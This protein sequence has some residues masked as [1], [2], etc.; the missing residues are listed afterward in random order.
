MFSFLKSLFFEKNETVKKSYQTP[1][2]TKSLK[3]NIALFKAIFDNDDTIIY[4][5]CETLNGSSCC[6]IFVD[7]MI[8]NEVINKNVI[9]RIMN[10]PIPQDISTNN[11][12]DFFTRKVIVVDDI[13][14]KT[15]L[16]EITSSILYGD[17]LLL[18]DGVKEGLLLNS[19][20]WQTRAISEPETENVV[21]GPREGF[22]ESMSLNISLLR[23]K[24]RTPQ[25]KF[26]FKEMGLRT[27][28]KICICYIEDLASDKILK[29]AI[30]RLNAIDID[31]ILESGY[32]EEF[33]Q[34]SPLSLFKTIGNTERPD[35]LAG[36]LLEGRI[37]ILCDGTPF[38]L[39]FPYV[40]LENFQA[41]ED[42]YNNF[43]VASLNRILRYIGFFL[44]TSIPAIYLALITYH[45]EMI[46]TPL[47]L[48]ISAARAGIPFPTVVETLI[49]GLS[50]EI[51][52]EGGVRLPKPI[53]QAL[54]IVGAI[55]IGEA[56]ATAK[57]ISSPMVIV[58]ALTGISGFATPKML[59]AAVLIRLTF[60]L[61]A[62]FFGMYGYMFG[63]IGL[64]IHLMSL[65][66]FGVPYMINF[67]SLKPQDL[68]DTV[69][70]APWWYMKLRPKLINK[71]NFKRQAK[72]QRLQKGGK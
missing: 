6:L 39:T 69:I 10:Y 48:S 67:D 26:Q 18:I 33:I 58:T 4:R 72:L 1:Q 66:S 3:K 61:L 2:I 54:N 37:G 5:E 64:F 14:N 44:T 55:V 19:K 32:I 41:N 12:I 71:K 53:G 47:L 52:R 8:N 57:L 50:F 17:T 27:K 31:G 15:D 11:L 45:Q 59:G 34:D 20:G 35:I 38:A 13:K 22:T 70:R 40:F 62:S 63:V 16:D 30:K 29:E 65:R 28:T 9:E 56:A 42:Y 43:I 36:K 49:I 24:I 68:K 60:L 51:L 21:R 23:R 7:G 46:P 25:L